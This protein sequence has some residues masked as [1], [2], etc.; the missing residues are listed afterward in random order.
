M[1]YDRNEYSHFASGT[2]SS[3]KLSIAPVHTNKINPPTLP[4]L[5]SLSRHCRTSPSIPRRSSFFPREH[6]CQRLIFPS[7]YTCWHG[8]THFSLYQMAMTE[9]Q[10]FQIST[11]SYLLLSCHRFVPCNLELAV[12]PFS[13]LLY[14]SHLS[15]FFFFFPTSF[16]WS[17]VV[18][19]ILFSRVEVCCYCFPSFF[20]SVDGRSRQGFW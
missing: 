6:N 20:F 12:T 19:N 9:F 1:I 8:P 4:V 17:N 14:T 10:F 18:Q 11:D 16:L 2:P 15:V 13:Y 7:L 5:R 3:F